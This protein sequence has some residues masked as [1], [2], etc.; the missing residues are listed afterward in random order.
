MTAGGAEGT[1]WARNVART[2]F[3]TPRGHGSMGAA[4]PVADR[5]ARIV[6][7]WWRLGDG[8]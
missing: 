6:A 3:F 4:E 8:C 2:M 1:P 5:S 7:S